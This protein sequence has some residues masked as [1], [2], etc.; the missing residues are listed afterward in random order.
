MSDFDNIP[1]YSQGQC[2][3]PA[4]LVPGADS[5]AYYPPAVTPAPASGESSSMWEQGFGVLDTLGKSADLLL[6]RPDIGGALSL[7]GDLN[8]AR[9]SIGEL[10]GKDYKN[11]I[12]D[13]LSSTAGVVSD[14]ANATG[15]DGV[16]NYAGMAKAGVELA[17]GGNE[18]YD[19]VKNHDADEEVNAA[20]DLLN[21]TADGLSAA[22]NKKVS[23]VGK[24]LSVGVGIGNAIAPT[25]FGDKNTDCSVQTADGQWHG[26]TGNG[27]IDWMAGVGKYSNSRW[28]SDAPAQPTEL[29]D[30]GPPDLSGQPM[31]E[32]EDDEMALRAVRGI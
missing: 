16:G 4:P 24:A 14:I 11:G 28:G 13:A 10:Q 1:D 17:K 23:M 21:G 12:P 18:L 32:E 6:E 5:S 3:D 22:P 27:Y 2:V 31:S 20:N 15:H 30:P 7:P 29:S 26:S 25:V 8:G 9:K 19:G